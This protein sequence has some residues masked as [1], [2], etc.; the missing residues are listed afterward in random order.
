MTTRP[1]NRLSLT[2]RGLVRAH[3]N[4]D[5]FWLTRDRVGGDLA[6]EVEVWVVRPE[7]HQ[8]EDG[9]VIWLA[10]F[11]YLAGELDGDTHVDDWSLDEARREIGS[12][13]PETDRECVRVGEPR[14]AE[15]MV[16]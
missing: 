3:Q 9:D 11:E 1:E 5:C 6:D 7:R 14:A 13:I 12:G 16:S 8:S 15:R 2:T 10:P 4:V